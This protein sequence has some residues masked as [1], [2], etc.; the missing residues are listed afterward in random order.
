[1]KSYNLKESLEI[2]RKEELKNIAREFDF[3][4]FSSKTK[5]DLIT[6][7]ENNMKTMDFKN[8]LEKKIYDSMEIFLKIILAERNQEIEE[9]Q[10]KEKFK[11]Y[12]SQSTY[13]KTYRRLL[14]WG[15]ISGYIREVGEWEFLIYVPKD[16]IDYLKEYMPKEPQIKENLKKDSEKEDTLFLKSKIW[17]YIK[18]KGFNT[19]RNVIEG[20]KLNQVIQTLLDQAINLTKRNNRKTVSS[21]DLI[22]I[23]SP[24]N[25]IE[26]SEHWLNAGKEYAKNNELIRAIFSFQKALELNDKNKLILEELGKSYIKTEQYKKAIEI[27]EELK[28]FEPKN[29]SIWITIAEIYREINKGKKALEFYEEALKIEPDNQELLIKIAKAREDIGHNIIAL[30]YYEKAQKISP[31]T[32]IYWYSL[33]EAYYYND[34][35]EKSIDAYL[36]AL[37]MDEVRLSEQQI[38]IDKIWVSLGLSYSMHENPDKAIEAFEAALKINPE[39]S[40]AYSNLGDIYDEKEE[41]DKAIDFYQKTLSFEPEDLKSLISLGNLYLKQKNYKKAIEVYEKAIKNYPDYFILKN[42]GDAYFFTK[43]YKKAA[44]TYENI[45]NLDSEDLDIYY[46]LAICLKN[47]K[48][49]DDAISLLEKSLKA[50]SEEYYFYD[51]NEVQI[52]NLLGN[53]YNLVKKPQKAEECYNKIKDIDPKWL[54]IKEKPEKEEEKVIEKKIED[55]EL[56]ETEY[57]KKILDF[58]YIKQKKV[59]KGDLLRKLNFSFSDCN[60]YFDLINNP[61]NYTEQEEQ[62][63]ERE[64]NRILDKFKKPTL[65]HLINKMG[66]KYKIAKKLGLYLEQKSWI[67]QFNNFPKRKDEEKDKVRK[68]DKH[69]YMSYS[70]IDAQLFKIRKLSEKLNE[71][72][73]IYEALYWEQDVKENI[74]EYMNKNLEKCDIMLLFCTINS[75]NSK[76]VNKEWNAFLLSGKP[77]V[78]IFIDLE[79]VPF[80]L[81]P[82]KGVKYY[83]FNFQQTIQEIYQQI[84]NVLEK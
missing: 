82:N 58:E 2:K 47:L 40:N 4:G 54:I 50:D 12:R 83:P 21:E 22:A 60:K 9:Y 6:F 46:I 27:Y 43:N 17:N 51:I 77:I 7:I 37:N 11:K 69:I 28:K 24:E 73:D 53:L 36:K 62:E 25:K 10:L 45:L 32:F 71:Y 14:E 81:K 16:L 63:L 5:V 70:T 15:L 3:S 35:Y 42:L 1:M 34:Q 33:G 64:V 8:K 29:I 84:L 19:S 72:D 39:N 66:Y 59:N 57:I 67:Q 49:Y 68:G 18:N 76:A 78:P 38:S 65:Y 44:D 13:Y 41:Y 20:V 75:N 80:I 74:A 26:M 55:I 52:L 79:F 30:G 61:V 56:K 31:D 23:T 48:K